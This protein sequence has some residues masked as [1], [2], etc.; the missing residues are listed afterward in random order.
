MNSPDYNEALELIQ[1][2]NGP[3][4]LR[5]VAESEKLKKRLEE[6]EKIGS[7]KGMQVVKLLAHEAPLDKRLMSAW[8]FN[9][10]GYAVYYLPNEFRDGYDE[11]YSGLS[12]I[13]AFVVDLDG[14][15][16]DLVT[17]CD[18]PP[19]YVVNTSPG[20]FQCIWIL[21]SKL[22][23]IKIAGLGEGITADDA[24]LLMCQLAEM[25][26]GD[27]NVA[28]CT[29]V[30]RLPGFLHQKGESYESN[31]SYRGSKCTLS[32]LRG[33]LTRQNGRTNGLSGKTG[34]DKRHLA[35]SIRETRSSGDTKEP[36]N[37][38]SDWNSMEDFKLPLEAIIQGDYRVTQGNRHR[39]HLALATRFFH[40]NM[41]ET[42]VEK[43]LYGVIA[44]S[45]DEPETFLAGG[46]RG[47]VLKA[48]K[49]AKRYYG[50]NKEEERLHKKAEVERILSVIPGGSNGLQ[51]HKNVE[52]GNNERLE[53]TDGGIS[54]FNKYN[55]TSIVERVLFKYND[56]LA[57]IEGRVFC[58]DDFDKLWILQSINN[59]P[60]VKLRVKSAVAATIR[61]KDFIKI[62]CLDSK[63]KHDPR[64]QQTVEAQF[65]K[66]NVISGMCKSVLGD[67]AVTKYNYSDFD[68]VPELIYLANGVLNM[69]TLEIREALATDRLMR[70]S[71]VVWLGVN[72]KCEGWRQ[73][74]SEVFPGESGLEMISF[75][76][77]LFGYSLSGSIAEEKIFCH[78]GQGANGKSKL[79][80]ALSLI[81]GEYGTFIEPDEL[82]TKKN[83]FVKS[84]E[85]T[86]S[87]VEGRRLALIDDLDI[88]TVWNEGFVKTLTAKNIRARAEYE[89]SRTI[90]NRCKFHIG[91]NKAPEPESENLGILRRLCIIPYN[92]T[93]QPNSSSE[94]RLSD[95]IDAE[96][97]GILAWAVEGYRRWKRQGGLA[98]PE[99]TR[100][101]IEDYKQEH[102]KLES[103]INE[104]IAVCKEGDEGAEWVELNI[105][106]DQLNA[107]IEKSDARGLR[108]SNQELGITLKLKMGFLSKR[109]NIDKKTAKITL[110]LVKYL[111]EKPEPKNLL[112]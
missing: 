60:Q 89:Q 20:K 6:L 18:L 70:Q 22:P 106:C 17:N 76:Q 112:E 32:S 48:I 24:N 1:A 92:V 83:G 40:E 51:S 35:R 44:K 4:S 72:C 93:F 86:G 77:E 84:F 91:L 36:G 97:S 14:A 10:K 26:D 73:F 9:Q 62:L 95:M 98:Y 69:D 80:S 42:E 50:E 16:L 74:L 61:E 100:L 19:T 12:A 88:A 81:L 43:A 55:E 75:M 65:L 54:K 96:A 47:E 63:G 58:F 110:Y 67:I 29:Q 28:V 45:F 87:K 41:N 99:E 104:M 13:R 23:V 57:K 5:L 52:T 37:V 25:F 8:E 31:I 101:A 90:A 102:F 108:V 103:A 3:V 71:S 56:D 38:S 68:S 111:N 33:L 34:N 53:F 11:S 79:L 82:A 27:L 15:P 46:R 66:A 59:C 107:N 39:A 64:K 105:L 2:L 21:E 85:R 94:K 78:Y 7:G 49:D 30:F 109:K